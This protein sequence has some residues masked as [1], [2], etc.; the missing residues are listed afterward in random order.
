MI[1][2]ENKDLAGEGLNDQSTELAFDPEKIDQGKANKFVDWA[3]VPTILELKADLDYAKPTSDSHKVNVNGWASLRDTSGAEAPPTPKKPGRSS[4]QPRLIRKH[5]EWRYPALS[6]PFLNSDRM[7]EVK[8]RTHEDAAAARQ[9]QI[10]IN[11]QFDTKLR[12][13]DLIDRIVRTFVDEGTVVLRVGWDRK[14]EKV[15]S[16]RAVYDYYEAETDEQLAM[17]AEASALFQNS[18]EEFEALPDDLKASVE[19]GFENQVAVVAVE[20]GTEEFHEVRV[21]MNQPSVKVVD[22]RNLYV[23]P[24]CDGV[25]DEAQFM[26]YTYPA[27]KSEL[28]KRKIFKNL[29]NVSWESNSVQAQAGSDEHQSS[30]PQIDSRID[31]GK[32][33]S[34][35]YE[36]WGLYDIHKNGS[37]VPIVVSWIGDTIIQME[38]NPFP[39]RKPP[40]ILAPYMPI[41]RSSFGEA[42]ASLLQE[43]Q[44]II[45]AVTRGVI[46]LMGRSANAQTGYKKGFLDPVNKRRFTTGEDFEFNPN[47]DPNTSVRQM[48]YPEIPNSAFQVLAAQNQEAEGLSGVKSF[49][50]GITGESYGKVAR[51][52]S[53]AMDAAGMREMSILRR[54]SELMRLTAVKIMA[55]NGKFLDEPEV[56]RVTNGEFIKIDQA[57]LEGNFD[58]V[59]DISTAKSDEERAGDLGFMLQTIGPDMDP[60]LSQIVLGKIADLKR[61][62]E[63]AEQIRQYKPEPDPLVQK[64]RELEIRKLEADIELAQARSRRELAMAEHTDQDTEMEAS[65]I[66]QNRLVE[67][68]GAQAKGNRELE[69]TKELLKGE[70]PTENVEAAVGFGK[71]TDAK[72]ESPDPGKEVLPTQQLGPLQS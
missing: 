40:F 45:G 48:E 21:V 44:R 63:L 55:M 42:D 17:L 41:L 32:Q 35:V 8:P 54:L 2:N 4:V 52:I 43:S 25:W 12:K 27:T 6:E 60:G 67:A 47:N 20:A 14:E 38:E 11:Y 64:Q 39:D 59:V 49:A 5:N 22:S 62:P 66:K 24:S 29:N 1:D 71:L 23:D 56:V 26:I 13:V 19:Y 46:D 51:G 7:F 72:N 16:E 30:S 65:G 31:K 58:M 18:P 36:Y 3:R 57:S 50:G 53:G 15:L 10:L 28:K 61:M 37:M 9:N 70:S 68:Q 33:Q 34:V 69:I